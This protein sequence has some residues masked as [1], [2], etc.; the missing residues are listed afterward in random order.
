MRRRGLDRLLAA[1]LL[2][3]VLVPILLALLLGLGGLLRGLGDEVGAVV[4]GR[5]GIGL[6]LAWAAA[7]AAATLLNGIIA[8]DRPRRR[9]PRD[10]RRRL[11]R[12]RPQPLRP[13]GGGSPP[14][15][16]A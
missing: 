13:D 3:G 2:A 4:C 6:G 14:A 15:A 10:R 7:L 16:S 12:H 8:L 11:R 5:I 9:V 1:A